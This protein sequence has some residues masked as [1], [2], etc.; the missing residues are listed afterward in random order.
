MG[1][2]VLLLFGVCGLGIFLAPLLLLV[3]LW[4]RVSQLRSDVDVLQ[5]RL[6]EQRAATAPVAAALP[7]ETASVP[8]EDIEI[9]G[10][11][12]APRP[13]TLPTRRVAVPRP[14]AE[15]DIAAARASEPPAPAKE[16]FSFEELLAGKWLTWVAAL[17]LIIGAGLFFKY[18]IE[19]ELI[20]E[21]G[22]VALGLI[23]G[24][25]AF[26]GAAFAM[27][28]DYRWFGQ[29]LAGAA[30]GILYFALYAAF[31]FYRLIDVGPAF[32]AMAV[33]T[34]LLLAF[35]TIFD[36]QSTAIL[37]LIGGFLTPLMLSQGQD[38]Q[39]ELFGYIFL[40]DLGVL[41]IASFRRWQPLQI[42]AF[43]C[44]LLLWSAW[45]A[46]QYHAS[47]LQPTVILL[48]AFFVLF[49]LLGV[50]HTVLRKLPTRPGDLFLMLATP[51]VYFAALYAVTKAQYASW[52]GLMAV[53]L[54]AVYVAF[55]GLQLARN[56]AG[57][58]A[59]LTHG[60]IAASFMTVAIPLQ[61]TG[62]WIAIAWAAESLLLVELGL[63]FREPKLRL[64]GFA[65]LCAVQLILC[66]YTIET[67]E[68]PRTF[69]T[70]FTQIDYSGV[71][72][73]DPIE[74]EGALIQMDPPRADPSW[75]DV[76]NGRS[77]SFLASALVLAILAWEYQ[78]RG[79]TTEPE[80]TG[81][82]AG[83]LSA[84]APITLMAML[85]LESF[86]LADAFHWSGFTLLGLATAW[87]SVTA[88][89][90]VVLG[91][92]CGPRWLEDIA[93]WLFALVGLLLLSSLFGTFGG[94]R[95]EWS[96]L[97]LADAVPY[98]R[99]MIV[100]PRGLGFVAAIAC[101]VVAMIV[102]NRRQ[103]PQGESAGRL[104]LPMSSLLGVFAHLSGL[105]MLT[106]E[107]YALGVVRGWQT[108]T[109]LSI[110][111]VWLA[112]ALATLIGG[113]YYRSATVR[114]LALLLFA[115]T[116]GKVF[117]Y[118][119]WHVS[120]AW[121]TVAFIA[122]GV[123]LMLVSFFYRRYRERI[124]AWMQAAALAGAALV[125][126]NSQSASAQDDVSS[127]TLREPLPSVFGMLVPRD[128]DRASLAPPV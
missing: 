72:V 43:A 87:V 115:V 62:H 5:M 109:A 89:A 39:W 93:V 114:I 48:T 128:I 73:L 34:L 14:P 78:R 36:A 19:N 123:A 31:D 17:A 58:L 80:V 66:A 125:L 92:A 18:S 54:G 95:S 46:G 16:P 94:W 45:F 20:G 76:L 90:V 105:L 81:P 103:S 8:M 29:A 56:P 110:T 77:L 119:V 99:W 112:Y 23:V 47:K 35:S 52:H 3:V 61:F 1:E 82:A 33:V 85:T 37:G 64:A 122:L 91:V 28:R 97:Q 4:A 41:G 100:N 7:R 9:V 118:D 116:A 96:R 13:I 113:I 117:L 49:A 104:P 67:V 6:R 44:T 88:L 102:Q 32:A 53:G 106:T 26:A 2:E 10:E 126:I 24:A 51:V 74:L 124:R 71:P 63:K 69:S 30:G 98:W 70:R 21:R 55:A 84:A 120:A 59:V 12:P 79:R 111:L 65:L 127:R 38:R 83:W 68:N 57:R 121:K 42:T 75:T 25:A 11:P 108:W 15:Q 40:L 22:R 27:L 86:V 60:G 107:V 50:W 101:A